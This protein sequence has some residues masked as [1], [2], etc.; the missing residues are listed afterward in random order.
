MPEGFAAICNINVMLEPCAS[1]E[2]EGWLPLRQALWPHR[3]KVEHIAEMK[4]FLVQTTRFAQFVAYAGTHQAVG[5][6]E[7]S[8]RGDYVNGTQSSPAAFLEGVYVLPENRCQGIARSLV[9][10]VSAW[11][12]ARGCREFASDAALENELSH[13]VH[14]SLGFEET[15]R[16]VY[17]RKILRPSE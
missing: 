5:F 11:A 3:S 15:E 13:D 8:I 10:A 16:V 6:V 12:V 1:V 2:Q 4:T 17:F 7:A 14:K 9:G